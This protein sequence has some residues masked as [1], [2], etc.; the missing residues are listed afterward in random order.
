MAASV[1]EWFRSYA[2]LALRLERVLNAKT[3]ETNLIYRGPSQWQEQAAAE[4][5]PAPAELVETCMAV[6]HDLPFDGPRATFVDAQLVAMHTVAQRL[7]GASLPF[8]DDASQCLGTPLR[9]VPES[10]LADAH[11]RLAAAL[12]SGPGTLTDRLLAWRQAHTIPAEAVPEFARQAIEATIDRTR[13]IVSLPEN[14]RIEVELDPGAHRGH[15]GGDATGTIH[16]N[17]SQ[18]FNGADLLSI[19]AHEG[20]P[21][22]IAES[23]LKDVLSRA[24]PEHAIRFLLSPPFVVSE[25]IGLHAQHIIFPDEA[26]RWLTDQVFAPL[27]ITAVGDFAAI[28]EARDA[29]W[30]AWG[31]AAIMAA[32][33]NDDSVVGD[34]LRRWALLSETEAAW[35]VNAV[36]SPSMVVTGSLGVSGGSERWAIYGTRADRCPR[37]AR[38]PCAND[39]GSGMTGALGRIVCPEPANDDSS[40]ILLGP[41]GERERAVAGE[42]R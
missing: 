9:R 23:L 14:L 30:G 19:V 8:L 25:G 13:G 22:H 5:L 1:D 29:L 12:P 31:N 34:Y 17:N 28:H 20:F 26:Q 27:G 3:G 40:W 42:P 24:E 37:L 36:R 2:E 7:G 16:L 18:P 33:D 4:P 35:A 6:R 15:Y 32:D 11:D 10:D 41:A 38:P 39:A 21:G